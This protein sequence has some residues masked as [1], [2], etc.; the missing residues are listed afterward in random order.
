MKRLAITTASLLILIFSVNADAGFFGNLKDKIEQTKQAVD[1]AKDSVHESKETVNDVT[2]NDDNKQATTNSAAPAAN[3]ASQ[4][5][6]GTNAAV[7]P[8]NTIAE[9]KNYDFVPG[10]K[11][12][13]ESQLDDEDVGEIPSQ[14]TLIQGQ[15]DI[16]EDNGENVI[17]IPKGAGATFTPRMNKKS[18]LPDQFTLEFDEKN[19]DYG[20]AHLGIHFGDGDGP[21][22]K[23]IGFGRGDS[24]SWT[25]GNISFP[26]GLD[27]G[28][29]QRMTW[30]HVAVAIN[31]NV[32]KIY[33]DQYRVANVNNI[34]G[35]PQSIVLQIEGFQASFI[36]NLRI[37]AGGIANYK[38]VMT[39]GKIVTHGILFDVGKASLKPL[40][41]GPINSIYRL[42]EHHASLKF[43]IDGHTDNTG[44]AA[45]NLELSQE[46]A[47]AV[48]AQLVS[49]GI[50][51]SRLK[52]KGYGDT[53]P[54]SSNSTPEGRANN[55]RVEFIQ[56]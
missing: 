9:Y 13:F 31:K 20:L 24:V 7:P 41:M 21:E 40:S 45:K 6:S 22:I 42:L 29:N 54:I 33:I 51:G 39:D 10:D 26:E 32:G 36:K 3:S 49:M 56:I 12:I 8:P 55:R 11:I 52:T 2:G 38:K 19:Q 25:T 28:E 53:K 14:F 50:A 27:L 34:E 17:R 35:K 46:R 47:D 44:D 15:M 43:E 5:A 4:S 18:W 23:E 16:E 1:D 48:K 37:A 30:H